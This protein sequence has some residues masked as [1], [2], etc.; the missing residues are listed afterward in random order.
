MKTT[1][2]GEESTANGSDGS[3]IYGG[4][5]KTVWLQ[6]GDLEELAVDGQEVKRFYTSAED[7]HAANPVFEEEKPL[8]PVIET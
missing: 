2:R 3:T 5:I 6:C 1:Y 7:W 4:L 8:G